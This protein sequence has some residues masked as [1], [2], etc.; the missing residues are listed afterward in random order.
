VTTL[1]FK[2]DAR[3][4]EDILGLTRVVEAS[5]FDELWFCED[6]SLAGGIAQ[7]SAALAVTTGLGVGLGIAPAAVRNPVYLA[8][9]FATLARMSGGR[10]LAG[11]GHGMP[12]WLHQVGAHPGSLMTRLAEVSEVV[13]DLLAGEDVSYRGQEVSVDRAS[14][15]HP[16][17]SPVPLSLGVRGPR[18]IELARQLGAG[19]ILAEG[20]TAEYVAQVRRTLGADLPITVFVWGSLDPADA[21]AARASLRPTIEAAL[22]KPY[23]S[24]QLG[25]L[26]GSGYGPAVAQRLSVAGDAQDCLDAIGLLFDSGADHVVFQPVPGQ[27]ER[28]I[29]LFGEH[30]VPAVAARRP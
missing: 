20:S 2:I 27:E 4:G 12:G 13:R 6:L 22:R 18:G 9:E 15:R 11:I 17:L 23:L 1:G 8:M 7:V 29:A 24:A 3:P 21:T 14:L 10:L 30:V 16:P 19:V 25:D 28:Q 5:G 26:H